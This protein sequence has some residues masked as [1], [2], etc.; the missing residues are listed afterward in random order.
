MSDNNIK[1]KSQL[2]QALYSAAGD[3]RSKMDANEY[4]NYLLG[5]IFYK[6]LSD[7][8]LYYVG[9]LIGDPN[10]DL[11]T[12]QKLYEENA[13]DEELLKE[14]KRTFSYTISP[15]HTFT[16]LLNEING[17]ARTQKGELKTFQIS[18]LA[19]AFNDI[20]SISVFLFT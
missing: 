18:D 15:R 12:N 1:T 5:I 19:E 4:K 16:Y 3:L 8:M 9:Q 10:A 6:Y 2:E 7:K 20:E 17:E 13:E 14:L 11:K